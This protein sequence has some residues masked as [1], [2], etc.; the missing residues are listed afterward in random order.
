MNKTSALRL[1]DTASDEAHR[2]AR[3]LGRKRPR[4]YYVSHLVRDERVW[5]VEGRFGALFGRR[6]T[7]AR[8]CFTDVRV[9]SYR[10]DQV[11]DGGLGDNS[12]DDESFNYVDFP[13]G[14]DLDGL[15]HGFWKL[16][17]ARYREA[18]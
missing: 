2:A 12:Q 8:S 5:R 4:A 7:E 17:D 11:Q 6:E 10:Y 3:H 13:I 14:D 15:R 16:T 1:A 9:G 18:V